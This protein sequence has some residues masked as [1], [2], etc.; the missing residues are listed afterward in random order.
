M[1]HPH[2]FHS[3]FHEIIPPHC[4]WLIDVMIDHA[5]PMQAIM[6]AQLRC[7]PPLSCHY[8]EIFNTKEQKKTLSVTCMGSRSS[9]RWA[10]A[11]NC[12]VQLKPLTHL[13]TLSFVLFLFYFFI[14]NSLASQGW[15]FSLTLSSLFSSVS[16]F[17]ANKRLGW[18]R[19]R[20]RWQ[21]Y[22]QDS[23]EKDRPTG[24]LIKKTRRANYLV[25]KIIQR[26]ILPVGPE[27]LAG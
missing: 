27:G 4:C 6:A 15:S 24:N 10:Q 1:R 9:W 23:R 26:I 21:F 25:T 19:C 20:Y 16:L 8:L 14:G 12:Q 2:F 18:G 17:R 5:C 22:G 11:D 7:K 3:H 13:V